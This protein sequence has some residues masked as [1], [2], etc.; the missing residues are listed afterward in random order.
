VPLKVE[1]A[2]PL[3][4]LAPAPCRGRIGNCGSLL[5]AIRGSKFC[6]TVIREIRVPNAQDR[7]MK[8]LI[9]DS[10]WWKRQFVL[11][12]LESKGAP[13]PASCQ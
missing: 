8:N 13:L 5:A 11:S 12:G 7:A 10:S 9:K 4:D 3:V 1:V 2:Q 6:S